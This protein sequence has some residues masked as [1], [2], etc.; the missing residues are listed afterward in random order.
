MLKTI[1]A[2]D[3]DVGIFRDALS[4]CEALADV[5]LANLEL[6][7]SGSS[8]TDGETDHWWWDYTGSTGDGEEVRFRV[9]YNAPSSG[10]YCVAG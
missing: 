6:V 9:G 2:G 5:D 10:F 1:A 3:A 4:R 7:D 8:E